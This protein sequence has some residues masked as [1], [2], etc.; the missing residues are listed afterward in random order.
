MGSRTLRLLLIIGVLAA[1]LVLVIGGAAIAVQ[2]AG[3]GGAAPTD[4]AQAVRSLGMF[5][6]SKWTAHYRAPSDEQIEL[7]LEDEG[8]SLA[9]PEAKATAIQVFRQE[10][11]ERNPTTPNPKKLRKLL[12]ERAQGQAR[13][14][15]RASDS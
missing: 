1:L 5:S 7:L 12:E 4:I 2:K 8:I 11:A 3:G 9:G 15:D 6:D 14:G 13:P 10:W